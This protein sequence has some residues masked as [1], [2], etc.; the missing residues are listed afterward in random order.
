MLILHTEL[1]P[2]KVPVQGVRIK[3]HQEAGIHTTTTG[4][5]INLRRRRHSSLCSRVTLTV[6]R[7]NRSKSSVVPISLASSPSALAS[8]RLSKR[9]DS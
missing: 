4:I 2:R 6:R 3:K 7:E 1:P 9:L 8:S 5:P